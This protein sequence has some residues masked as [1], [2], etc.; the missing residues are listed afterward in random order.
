MLSE[1]YIVDDIQQS[2]EQWGV[3]VF[4][5]RIIQELGGKYWFVDDKAY[6]IPLKVAVCLM[7]FAKVQKDII[8]ISIPNQVEEPA[9]LVSYI[10]G[11]VSFRGRANKKAQV[12]PA[13]IGILH[14]KE[15]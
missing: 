2:I 8:G 5:D 9:R 14:I 7:Q 12:I 3:D 10:P 6:E 15:I 11:G 4:R 1:I 13:K